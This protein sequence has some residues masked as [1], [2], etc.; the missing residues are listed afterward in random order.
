MKKR[1]LP[2]LVVRAVTMSMRG[3]AFNGTNPT[4]RFRP[5]ERIR[6]VLRNDEST[7][8]LHDFRIVGM[9]VDGGPPMKPGEIR[10]VSVTMPTSGEFAYTCST[11]PGMGGTMVV[12]G[13]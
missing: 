3:Y 10:E 8:I 1:L 12:G 13:K 6:F 4:L 7:N 9:N 11:H 2:L 5:G